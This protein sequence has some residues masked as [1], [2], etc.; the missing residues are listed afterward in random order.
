[1]LVRHVSGLRGFL[2]S[3][4][5][6][7]EAR[8]RIER[9]HAARERSFLHT[10]E[11]GVYDHRTSPYRALLEHIG[12]EYGDFADLVSADGV[13]GALE[14]LYDAGCYVSLDEFKG[15]R[16][17]VRNGLELPVRPEGF[18][19]PLLVGHYQARTGGS[20][21]E[22]RRLA[23]DLDLLVQ[24]AAYY[25]LFL[26]AFALSE[27]PT[28]LWR[29]LPP[30]TAGIANA[31]IQ[32][33]I[34]RPLEQWFTQTPFGSRQA[35]I[36]AV[37]FLLATLVATHI[38]GEGLPWPRHVPVGNPGLVASW[39]ARQTAAGVPAL[40]DT[41]ASG[42][43]RV[44][45]L[46]A[47]SGL[48]VSGTFFR[49]GG[50]PFTVAKRQRIVD[51]GCRAACHYSMSEVGRL[52]IACG[53]PRALDDVHLL[54]DKLAALQ[55]R[56]VLGTTGEAVGI[57]VYSTLVPSVPKL[58]LNVESDDYAEVE[59]REC[60]CPFGELGLSTHL[61]RIRSYE[62]LTSEGMNYLGSDLI[63][64]VEEVLPD[65][66]G[67]NPTDYQ[68]VE[69]EQDGAPRI[70]VVASP[71]VGALDEAEVIS[72]VLAHLDNDPAMGN[73]IAAGIWRAGGTLR[74]V[75]REP[76]ATSAA[77]ILALHVL[78]RDRSACLPWK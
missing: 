9:Q 17:I 75:R 28:A 37:G 19:N 25:A 46:A 4:I 76:Y 13:E 27:R 74:L 2:G 43:V 77:K 31:L 14:R 1:M 59:E 35:P 42:A 61:H 36:K 34:G 78:D 62:K 18:D 51:A 38:F 53:V 52:G 56:H 16:P 67:G 70:C 24:D 72:A 60:G 65:R 66:F 26:D 12:V 22:R 49:I 11:R 69:E 20:R 71:G 57:L 39:L 33:K 32:L 55:R 23:I 50:E 58:M 73:R 40:V 3:P 8:A 54:T 21:G 7:R 63:A 5:G 10:V 64:L 47:A 29:P 30:A 44:C 68:L 41:S 45:N 48:D 15:R 6:V